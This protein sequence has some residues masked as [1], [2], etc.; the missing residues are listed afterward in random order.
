M[1]NVEPV[2]ESE[3]QFGAHI[4]AG[5][6][7]D[8]NKRLKKNLQQTKNTNKAASR[9]FQYTKVVYKGEQ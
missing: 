8:V 9:M 1:W 2:I 5:Y 3:R 6:L 4:L 7:L